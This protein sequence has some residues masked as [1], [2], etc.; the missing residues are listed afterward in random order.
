MVQPVS[1]CN[2]GDGL[3]ADGLIFRDVAGGQEGHCPKCGWTSPNTRYFAMSTWDIIKSALGGDKHAQK[4]CRD[5][6]DE[7]TAEYDRHKPKTFGASWSA[8]WNSPERPR[9]F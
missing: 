9:K 6:A 8:F 1:R 4:V 2:H 3:D 5:N 7:V